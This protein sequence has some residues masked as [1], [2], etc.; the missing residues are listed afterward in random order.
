VGVEVG[1]RGDVSLIVGETDTAVALRSGSVAVLGT[2]RLV[3]LFEE[4]TM[5]ALSGRLPTGSTTVGMR[6]QIDHLQP[7]AVGGKVFVDAVLERIEGR[8]LTFTV[9]ASDERGLVAAGKVTR[10]VVDVEKFLAKSE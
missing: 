2:P 9:S 8:R 3:A 6:V 10:V 7:T 5:A 4:A 1:L